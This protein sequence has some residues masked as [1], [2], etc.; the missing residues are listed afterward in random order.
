MG[1]GSWARVGAD[2][3]IAGKEA[4]IFLISK[5]IIYNKICKTIYDGK[6][7]SYKPDLE[8]K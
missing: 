7:F 4:E 1:I 3:K 5:I 8:C 6:N 2:G